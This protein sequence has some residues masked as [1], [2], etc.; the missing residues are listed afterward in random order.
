[1][2]LDPL[3]PACP[4]RNLSDIV[5]H[6][7]QITRSPSAQS[8]KSCISCT[9][10]Q[11]K[12]QNVFRI[13]RGHYRSACRMVVPMPAQSVLR[14][15]DRNRTQQPQSP[16][17]EWRVEAPEDGISFTCITPMVKWGWYRPPATRSRG[18]SYYLELPKLKKPRC[19]IQYKN[20]PFSYP[21][22][23]PRQFR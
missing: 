22:S 3:L 6:E 13:L 21:R 14:Y 12:K 1:M 8:R 16:L 2:N 4:N 15:T 10:C 20:H 5:K 7:V 23:N 9:S 19:S 11:K 18:R 17:S